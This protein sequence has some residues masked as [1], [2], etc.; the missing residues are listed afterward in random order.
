MHD[1]KGTQQ[2]WIWVRFIRHGQYFACVVFTV[3]IAL[4]IRCSN[5]WYRWSLLWAEKAF[6]YIWDRSRMI[7]NWIYIKNTDQVEIYTQNSES[8]YTVFIIYIHTGVHIHLQTHWPAYLPNLPTSLPPHT[9]IRY[10]SGPHGLLKLE[11]CGSKVAS[12]AKDKI[13]EWANDPQVAGFMHM[14]QLLTPKTYVCWN[15]HAI[16]FKLVL[17][18]YSRSKPN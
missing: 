5:C 3:V 14:L 8:P 6:I 2:T 9:H 16:L 4:I 12:A 7:I 1:D 11:N 18:S 17:L 13:L 15:Q 10:D